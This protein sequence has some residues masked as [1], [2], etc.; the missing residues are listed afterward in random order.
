[1]LR[2]RRRR[3]RWE[4]VMIVGLGWSWACVGDTYDCALLV[5]VRQRNG[6]VCGCV[7]EGGE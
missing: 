4:G 2:D 6:F 1:M 3:R 7:W 5:Q